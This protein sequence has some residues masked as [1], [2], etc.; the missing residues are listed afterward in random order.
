[1]SEGFHKPYKQITKDC[2]LQAV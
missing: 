2:L 1:V